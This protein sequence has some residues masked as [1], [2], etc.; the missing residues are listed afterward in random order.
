MTA[1]T[2]AADA[3]P[4]G[5]RK[6]L[7][8][9]ERARHRVVLWQDYVGYSESIGA[10]CGQGR[11]SWTGGQRR[12]AYEQYTQQSPALGLL[13]TWHTGHSQKKTHRSVG[14]VSVQGDPHAVHVIVTSR[15][16]MGFPLASV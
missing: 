5:E 12:S 2:A 8:A 16:A 7:S 9:V 3:Y 6:T 14:I 11:S 15:T 13:T 4:R 1:H 10:G